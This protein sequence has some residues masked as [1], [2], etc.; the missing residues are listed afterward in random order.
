MHA[1]NTNKTS[2]QSSTHY[3]SE[4]RTQ[5]LQLELYSFEKSSSICYM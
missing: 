2:S 5:L 1:H 4:L 3:T